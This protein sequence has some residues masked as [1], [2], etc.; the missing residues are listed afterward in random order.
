MLRTAAP[1]ESAAELPP[2]ADDFRRRERAYAREERWED[3]ASLLIEHAEQ[4]PE[5]SERARCLMRAALTFQ[6]KLDDPDRAFITMLAAFQECPTEEEVANGLSLMASANNRWTDLLAECNSFATE[7][8]APKRAQVLVAMSR[9]YQNDL[10]DN[11]AAEQSLE[12]A[13]AADPSNAAALRALIDLCSQRGEWARAAAYLNSA[14]SSAVDLSERIELTLQAAEIFQSKL[15]D[16]DAAAEQYGRV[17]QMSPHHPKAVEALTSTSWERKD[18]ATVLPLLE[19]A[20]SDGTE[21]SADET[22]RLYQRAGWAAQML[23]DEARAR[24]HYRRSHASRP[25]YLPNLLCWAELALREEWSQDIRDVVPLVLGRGE[26]QLTAPERIEY[27]QGLG[28]AHL[29]LGDMAAASEALTRALEMAP[30]DRTTRRLLAKAHGKMDGQGVSPATRIEQERLL[31]KGASSDDERFEILSEIAEIQREELNDQ[32]GA[33]ATLCEAIALRPGD[34][35]TLHGMMEIYSL[36]GHW[37]HA[38][39][40]LRALVETETGKSKSRYLV[41]TANILNYELN[42]GPEAVELY[43]Q[44]LDIDPEDRRSFER[45]ERILTNRSDWRELARN[46]RRMIKRLG[47]TPSAEQRTF[48][49]SLWHGL[50]ELCRTHLGDAPAAA[51]AYEACSKLAPDDRNHLEAMADCLESQG[52]AALPQAVQAREQLLQSANGA[53][54]VAKQIRALA[55]LHGGL[56]AYDRAFCAS[57]AMVA[58][59]KAD[60]QE[61][62]FYESNALPGVPL[63]GAA[64]NEALWQQTICDAA[65]DRRLSALFAAIGPSLAVV[66]AREAQ[67]WGIDPSSRVDLTNDRSSVSQILVYASR[68]TGVPLPAVYV[69]PTAPGE[70][71]MV[72][73]REP[74]HVAASFVLGRDLVAGRTEAELAFVLSRKLVALRAEYFVLWPQL[75]SSFDELQILLA[76]TIKLVQPGFELP[77]IDPSVVRK[78]SAT[79]QRLVSSAQMAALTAVVPQLLS[80]P[81]F[82]LRAWMAAAESTINRAGLVACGNV[83]AAARELV[84]EA[85]QRG[86]TPADAILNL[87]RWSASRDFMDLRE[88]LGLALVPSDSDANTPPARA[89]AR[90]S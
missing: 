72:P 61:R 90:R 25:D 84:K 23:G 46:F 7:A 33:L 35:D 17:L 55:R 80:G 31:L 32:E 21:R 39:E 51:A 83:V 87:T 65:E 56:R 13:L 78:T 64:L 11:V 8:P 5:G 47:P 37:Q 42:A 14:A 19:S 86:V 30:E 70:L 49:L 28:Q 38:V 24:D 6:D 48:T 58:L 36:A 3:L 10:G 53:N 73:V 82:D 44:A 63:A 22:A 34:P 45:I 74:Q 85:R 67:A 50:A 71:D 76:S 89:P 40:V 60:A 68:L 27:L 20:A 2:P 15:M 52:E 62:A 9:W 18:W 4:V 16:A 81:P 88:Q 79:M 29:E 66:R 75:V 54:A 43:N 26:A 57:A 12:G 59:L 69:P 41:A 1:P 77:G